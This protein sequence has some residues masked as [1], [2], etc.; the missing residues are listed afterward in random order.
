LLG[1]EK[2]KLLKSIGRGI[3]AQVKNDSDKTNEEVFWEEMFSIY[4]DK[5]RND[6]PYFEKFYIEKFDDVKRSCG[7]TERSREIID[8]VKSKGVQI[9]LATNPVFP[10]IATEKRVAW[11]GLDKDDFDYITTYE[12]SS[13]CKPRPIYYEEILEKNSLL[14]SECLMIGNDTLDDIAA[15]KI[16]IKTFILTDC[17][18]NNQN[19]DLSDI[20]HGSHDDL[21]D[22]INSHF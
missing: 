15:T 11:A 17:L 20:P 19:I 14:P 16:G 6:L 21:I 22:F 12:N 4:G 1:Y 8:L 10:R 13:R 7:F 9:I 5:I 18:I 3:S 2:A